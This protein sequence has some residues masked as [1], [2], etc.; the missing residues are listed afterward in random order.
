VQT[1][2]KPKNFCAFYAFLS[3]IDPK[4]V[5]EAL[6]DS[7]WVC[8]MQDELHQF[9]RNKVW[10]LVPWPED[11]SIIGAKWMFRTSLM[12]LEQLLGTRPG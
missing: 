12:S 11:R 2:T 10:H 9:E 8:A 4:N 1:R 6:V 7:D 3:N 5:N